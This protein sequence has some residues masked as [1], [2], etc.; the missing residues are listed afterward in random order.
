MWAKMFRAASVLRQVRRHRI[1]VTI[2]NTTVQASIVVAARLAGTRVIW[3]CH[4]SADSFTGPLMR[5][6]LWI[7]RR[8]AHEQVAVSRAVPST[9]RHSRTIRNIVKPV[10]DPVHQG[11]SILV[12][13]TKSWQKGV[14]RLPALVD[15]ARC[16]PT[17]VLDVV[18]WEHPRDH[19]LLLETRLHLE[20]V[21]GHR[22]RWRQAVVDPD[23]AYRTAAV[24]LLPSRSDTRPRVVEEALARGIPVVASRLPGLED[25]SETVHDADSLQL[26]TDADW[27]AA[28][29]RA[30]LRG[31]ADGSL[32][33]P[34]TPNEFLAAWMTV[35]DPKR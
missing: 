35:I 7:Y 30:L 13:G 6:R 16:H 21:W 4:E 24:L 34:F 19:D 26:V 31:T 9:P 33:Q 5:T 18:G 25:V 8:L 15:P 14:D 28:V 12:L 1:Q 10:S 27:P 29:A 20:D 11:R 22:L 32:I 2:V 23:D 3:W 17:T